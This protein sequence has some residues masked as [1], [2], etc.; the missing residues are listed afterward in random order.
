M[1]QYNY[2]QII[3]SKIAEDGM[4][5]QCRGNEE[6][7]VGIG[8]FLEVIFKQVSRMLSLPGRKVGETIF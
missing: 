4:D 5:N 3:Y 8:G 7:R 1:L 6:M 2:I